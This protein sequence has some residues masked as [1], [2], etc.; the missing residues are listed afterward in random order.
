[1]IYV[2]LKYDLINVDKLLTTYFLPLIFIAYIWKCMNNKLFILNN[3]NIH[4]KNNN[5]KNLSV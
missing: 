4:F 3:S 2:Y 1:M 5:C